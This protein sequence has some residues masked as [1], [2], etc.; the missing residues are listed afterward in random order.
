MPSSWSATVGITV[1]TAVASN[2]T[3]AQSANMPTVV[4]AY[5]G[6]SRIVGCLSSGAAV[7]VTA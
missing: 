3:N 4:A 1:T 6:D 2:A 7:K 5:A